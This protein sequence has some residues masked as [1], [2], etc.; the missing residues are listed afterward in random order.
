M[1]YNILGFGSAHGKVFAILLSGNI[2]SNVL[3]NSSLE[4]NEKPVVIDFSVQMISAFMV[5]AFVTHFSIVCCS[6]ETFC[7]SCKLTVSFSLGRFGEKTFPFFN[8]ANADCPDEFITFVA[9]NYKTSIFGI[10]LLYYPL[11]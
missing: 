3:S 6:C 1:I 8:F 4:W 2:T 7:F 9:Y 5:S 11:V 10:I